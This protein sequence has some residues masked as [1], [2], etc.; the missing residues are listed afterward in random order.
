MK[1][2]TRYKKVYKKVSILVK[3]IIKS[4]KQTMRLLDQLEK[5][6]YIKADELEEAIYGAGDE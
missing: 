1:N 5:M 4:N 3:K 6:D 2:A